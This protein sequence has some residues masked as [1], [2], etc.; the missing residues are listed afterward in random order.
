MFMFMAFGRKQNQMPVESSVRK[1]HD[2]SK[3]EM[4]PNKSFEI[5]QS[6]G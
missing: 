2:K 6:S 3:L 5:G 4:K 1:Q